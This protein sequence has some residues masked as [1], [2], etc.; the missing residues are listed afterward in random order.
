M[1]AIR[2]HEQG[3]PSVLRLD[4][5][6]DPNPGPG[7]VLLDVAAAGVNHLDIWVRRDLPRIPVPRI[8]G[9]DAAGTVAALGEGVTGIEVGDKVL[10][11]PG[12]SCGTCRRCFEG[13]HSLCSS[14]KILGESCNGTYCS[15]LAVPAVNCHPIPEG[16]TFVQAAAFPL[17]ALTAWRMCISRGRLRPGET[18]LILGAAAGVGVMCIQIAKMVG[19]RVI[20]TASTEAKRELCAALGADITIDYTADGWE[21]QV[22]AAAGGKVDVTIDY[23]G[24]ATWGSS[25]KLTRNGGRVLT[26][27]A[28]TGDATAAGL[29]HIFFRQLEIIGSTMGAR[30]DL[31]EALVAA[32]RGD[33]KPVL[34]GVLP[35]AE[36]AR[37]HQLIEDRGVL[38]K[39][40]LEV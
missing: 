21:K 35:L 23:V 6:D 33:L 25:L 30:S 12:L 15:K 4:E 1:R 2:F 11:D 29:S 24:G 13:E 7:E 36:A 26:C 9:A 20:A 34:D 3:P 16:W 17:V 37:A 40:V 22:R 18:V 14:F 28:T 38:G 27:G 8:P 39:L 31:A 32:N 5:V 10:I 19:C